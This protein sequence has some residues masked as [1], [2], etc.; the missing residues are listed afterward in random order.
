MGL[1]WEGKERVS[2]RIGQTWDSIL[3]PTN[4]LRQVSNQLSLSLP[5]CEGDHHSP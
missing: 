5:I 4:S 1:V 3:A 2:S